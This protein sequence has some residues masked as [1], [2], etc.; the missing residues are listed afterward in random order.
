MKTITFKTEPISVNKLYTGRRFLTKEGKSTKEAMAWEAKSQYR[1]EPL[2][3]EL[4][5]NVM[6]YFSSKRKDID[7]SL[8]ALFDCLSGILWEDDRQIVEMHVFK[9]IDEKNPRV[10]LQIL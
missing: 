10:V 3:G 8:K 9:L 6:F 4:I 2:K 7:N 1:G 5:L